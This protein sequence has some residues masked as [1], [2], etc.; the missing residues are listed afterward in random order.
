[1]FCQAVAFSEGGSGEDH[2]GRMKSRVH[3]TYNTKYRL[4]NW[5]SYDRALVRRRDITAWLSPEA[6]VGWEPRGGAREEGS[7][8][9]RTWRSKRG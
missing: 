7:G 6:I 8:D 4:R 2:T 3:P 1:M 9:T 5:A